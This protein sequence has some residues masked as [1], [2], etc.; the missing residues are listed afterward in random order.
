MQVLT[1]EQA[2][3]SKVARIAL[4][5]YGV[6]SLKLNVS[7]STGW[8]DRVFWIPGGRPLLIEFKRP[9]ETSRPRQLYIQTMLKGLGYTVEEHDDEIRA[10]QSIA[11]AMGAQEL[12]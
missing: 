3:E 10:L 4:Q 6:A 2:I 11:T 9:G 1:L 12:R 7:G 8:P 5:E